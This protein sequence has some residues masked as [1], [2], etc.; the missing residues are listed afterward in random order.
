MGKREVHLCICENA[1]GCGEPDLELEDFSLRFCCT[2]K[3]VVMLRYF[4]IIRSFLGQ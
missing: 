2:V 3:K 4:E 1:T